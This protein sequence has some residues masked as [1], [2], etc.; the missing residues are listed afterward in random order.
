MNRSPAVPTPGSTVAQGFQLETIKPPE[1]KLER[2]SATALA[3]SLRLPKPDKLNVL[4]SQ[5]RK[6]KIDWCIPPIAKLR[7]NRAIR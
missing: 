4:R 3:G 5:N 2:G 1:M 7:P 6:L